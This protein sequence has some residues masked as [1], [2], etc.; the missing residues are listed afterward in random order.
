MSVRFPVVN[1]R[2]SGGPAFITLLVV[3]TL[4]LAAYFMLVALVPLTVVHRG[5]EA[6]LLGALA[7]LAFLSPLLLAI[8]VGRVV[9]RVGP[10]PVLVIGT[11]VLALVVA[12]SVMNVSLLALAGLQAVVGLVQVLVLL[13]GQALAASLGEDHDRLKRMGLFTLSVAG[14][15]LLGPPI[16]G[17]VFDAAGPQASFAVAALTTLVASAAGLLLLPSA[18]ARSAI[19]SSADAQR[20]TVH[21]MQFVRAPT[22]ATALLASGTVLLCIGLIHTFLPLRLSDVPNPGTIVGTLLGVMA[23]SSIAVR[24]F[25]SQIA[26]RLGGHRAA[27]LNVAL[28]VLLGTVIAGSTTSIAALAVAVA[29]IGIGSGISQPLSIVM[30]LEDRPGAQH[31]VALGVRISGNRLAQ[32]IGPVAVGASASVLGLGPAMIG[33]ACVLALPIGAARWRARREAAPP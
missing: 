8:P 32:L 2:G 27:L 22:F 17:I 29:L 25:V 24:P 1:G 26:A 30:V 11:A 9:D 23:L 13:S 20:P 6:H 14:G 19:D 4:A 31:G 33:L 21:P 3:M 10:K 18:R 28:V 12:P 16:A 5:V 15:Q 7:S